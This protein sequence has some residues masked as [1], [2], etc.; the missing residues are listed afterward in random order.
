[1]CVCAVL[2]CMQEGMIDTTVKNNARMSVHGQP[3][4]MFF[5][6]FGHLSQASFSCSSVYVCEGDV[7]DLTHMTD[8][9]MSHDNV[10]W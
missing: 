4:V 7:T 10:T 1:M 2:V 6:V 5:S 9:M 3:Q 8:M